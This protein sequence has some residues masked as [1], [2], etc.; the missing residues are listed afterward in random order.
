[1]KITRDQIL[2][3]L[4]RGYCQPNT[5]MKAVDPDLANAMADQ[6]EKLLSNKAIGVGGDV[7]VSGGC[8]NLACP[9]CD[10]VAFTKGLYG[11]HRVDSTGS[12]RIGLDGKDNHY[13]AT[14][15]HCSHHWRLNDDDALV[16][17]PAKEKFG[18]FSAPRVQPF[19][20]LDFRNEPYKLEDVS[21]FRSVP[22]SGDPIITVLNPV[23]GMP[24]QISELLSQRNLKAVADEPYIPTESPPFEM[25]KLSP[26]AEEEV[27]NHNRSLLRKKHH[28]YVQALA[29]EFASMTDEEL[30]E[31]GVVL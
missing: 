6:V 31:K 1:M 19:V 7:K 11:W 17:D 3:A 25:K 2:G 28:D 15:C 29:E 20:P 5:Q 14:C 30:A 27:R 18:E 13:I 24:A 16:V 9:S 21:A 22:S 26:E 12:I 23:I 4:A 8:A 10:K